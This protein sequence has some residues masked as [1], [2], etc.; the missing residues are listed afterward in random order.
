MMNK[1]SIKVVI[2][3]IIICFSIVAVGCS[4]DR[5]KVAYSG[6]T[7]VDAMGTT[8]HIPQK[9][10]RILTLAMCTDSMVLGM[11][12]TTNLVGINNLADDPV[13]S[14]I[15]AKAKKIPLKIK[16]PSAEEIMAL[17]PDLIIATGWT[18]ADK[19][20][21][22]R[23]LGF[24]VIVI[25]LITTLE[26]IKQSI[27]IIAAALAEEEKGAEIINKMEQE[28]TFIREKIAKIPESSRKKVVLL[29][30]INLIIFLI[31]GSLFSSHIILS[32]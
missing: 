21:M 25:P 18:G 10:K 7:V 11:L 17:K 22:M 14:N 24:P 8:V 13:S 3:C 1:L 2:Y 32:I 23:K 19:V 29:S 27:N 12:P 26:D 6:Y 9:P 4:N 28:L 30:A 5:T 15:V 16:D 31:S 20:S